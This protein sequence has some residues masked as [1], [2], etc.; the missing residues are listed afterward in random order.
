MAGLEYGNGVADAVP[1]AP[2]LAQNGLE[3][4]L[5]YSVSSSASISSGW[6]HL[7]YS[8][9]T[10]GLFFNGLPQLKLDAFY[11]HVNLKTSEQ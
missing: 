11:L 7:V 3:A 4:S 9:G 8:R 2:R 5:G 1:G 6:Q 10:A